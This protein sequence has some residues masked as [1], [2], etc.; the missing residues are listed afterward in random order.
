MVKHGGSLGG[1]LGSLPG[2]LGRLA[3]SGLRPV[4]VHGGGPELSR[5]SARLGI[6]PRWRD[7]LRVTDAATLELAEMVL[8]GRVNRRLTAALAA[9]GLPAVG[10]A[11]LD[12]GLLEV[13]PAAPEE[14][15]GF[16]ARVR[17][18]EPAL[19]ETL[20]AGGFL[21]VVAPLGRAGE[22]TY[23][24]NADQVA[25]ALAAA[26][27]AT[28]VLLTDVPGV[29]AGGSWRTR[30]EPGE[31]RALL[32]SGEAAGGMRPKLEA[33]LEALAGG[34]PRVVIVD[35]RA[36]HAL[37]RAL[38]GE[39]EGVG[40]ELAPAGAGTAGRDGWFVREEAEG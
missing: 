35:G 10:L 4:V 31:A 20:A 16:V 29:S 22:Q 34:A 7:G 21:P 9:A 3:A 40:T 39:L 19:L 23:N 15:L 11:G 32:A 26:L 27:G 2:D 33:C 25:A 6:E 38:G 17:R 5:W 18:V 14:G 13:A 8:A 12:G 24:I 37:L 28:L 1:G 30:L 36:P